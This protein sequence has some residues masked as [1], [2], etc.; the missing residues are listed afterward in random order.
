MNNLFGYGLNTERCQPRE[1]SASSA[2]PRPSMGSLS[3]SLDG[4]PDGD[5]GEHVQAADAYWPALDEPLHST[6]LLP[7]LRDIELRPASPP[8][9]AYAVDENGDLIPAPGVIVD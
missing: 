9:P 5:E 1:T 6:V 2:A 7:A 8:E 4:N 3:P